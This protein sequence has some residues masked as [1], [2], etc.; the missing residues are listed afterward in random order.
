MDTELLLAVSYWN[1][2]EIR[3]LLQR[4]ANIDAVL[5]FNLVSRYLNGET[6][7]RLEILCLD[8]SSEFLDIPISL[9]DANKELQLLVKL[10]RD[11]FKNRNLAIQYFLDRGANPQL[12][13]D[14][15]M[16]WFLDP[17]LREESS[18]ILLYKAGAEPSAE[19]F[20]S[21]YDFPD[22]L[23]AIDYENLPI[24]RRKKILEIYL[25][26]IQD[27]SEQEPEGDL[28][29]EE[30]FERIFNSIPVS[31]EEIEVMNQKYPRYKYLWEKRY[32]GLLRLNELARN[33]WNSLYLPGEGK[34]Y[35][36][37]KK[38]F[39]EKETK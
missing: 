9:Q 32:L 38:H 37:G 11:E 2:S 25:E 30:I 23:D 1:V 15:E 19:S 18:A 31:Q 29:F 28:S 6:T 16:E 39:E 4:G 34:F 35:L 3:R 27:F 24:N 21:F 33:F 13:I 5:P 17:A 7:S 36:R 8:S 14:E 12:I 22:F 20:Y 26:K 10:P